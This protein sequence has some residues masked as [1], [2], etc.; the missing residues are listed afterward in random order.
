M[1]VGVAVAVV[2]TLSVQWCLNA[3]L[4][5]TL[6]LA[7]PAVILASGACGLLAGLVAAL[8]TW[9]GVQRLGRAER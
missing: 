3:W 8:A 2:A 9:A 5:D 1:V 6:G 7:E 4:N